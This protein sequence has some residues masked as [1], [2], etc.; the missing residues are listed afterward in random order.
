MIFLCVHVWCVFLLLS[1]AFMCGVLF[2][3]FFL[4]CSCVVCFSV[5]F[6]CVHVWCV[7]SQF[8]SC[9]FMCGVFFCCFH[10]RSCVVC[11]FSN[12]FL[13]VH[14]WCVFLLF[15][16]AFMCGV[17]FPRIFLCVQCVVCCF[18]I[19]SRVFM[20]G[21]CFSLIFLCV[22]VWCVFLLFSR[23]FMCGVF[24]SFFLMIFLCVHVWCMFFN[25]F[26]ACSCV[27]CCFS[28]FFLCVHVWR[29]FFNDFLVCSC[30]VC[31]SVV[32]TGPKNRWFFWG[33]GSNQICYQHVPSTCYIFL[34]PSQ[35]KRQMMLQRGGSNLLKIRPQHL[36]HFSPLPPNQIMDNCG[37]SKKKE[38]VTYIFH[39]SPFRTIKGVVMHTVLR[40]LQ[41]Y[42][43]VLY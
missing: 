23:V 36:L 8:F 38:I 20:C 35:T 19:F 2:L 26:L 39:T 30:V 18:S 7:V 29:M 5:V 3:K 13:C 43:A 1:R 28:N 40:F 17:C 24:F 41:F 10:L 6:T 31:F 33:G 15:S 11:C 27:V 42:L 37:I 12:I 4:V 21:V 25:D 32:F 16:R 14:V 22:H 34:R 9:V